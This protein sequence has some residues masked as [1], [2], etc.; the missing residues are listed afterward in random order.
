M[1]QVAIPERRRGGVDDA[2][3]L[4]PRHL[5]R[6]RV[7]LAVQGDEPLR[8]RQLRVGVAAVVVADVGVALDQQHRHPLVDVRSVGE[9]VVDARHHDRGPDPPVAA[10]GVRDEPVDGHPAQRH[11]GD[12]DL[13]VVDVQVCGAVE[14]LVEHE[15]GVGRL[16]HDL[17]L[18]RLAARVLL[19]LREGRRRHDVSRLRPDV[20]QRGE[21]TGI[22]VRSVHG[23]QQR[24]HAR[25]THR[26][27]H[28]GDEHPAP[29]GDPVSERV[30]DACDAGDRG[31]RW[32]CS[33]RRSVGARRRARCPHQPEF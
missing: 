6:W 18:Q 5:E 9:V 12:A 24:E 21:T 20:E 2:G 29:A 27:A 28:L 22:A 4:A 26:V 16:L 19:R 7:P 1:L 13:M 14:Q 11:P 31:T 32:W 23:Q 8:R 17:A 33:L 15:A 25:R 30:V 3:G 10:T